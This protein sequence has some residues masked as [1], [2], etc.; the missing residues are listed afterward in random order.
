MGQLSV[1]VT[2]TDRKAVAPEA[3]L[4]ARA[5][6]VGTVEARSK[7]WRQRVANAAS[8]QPLNRLYR[9]DHWTQSRRLL[10]A[11]T[12]AGFDASLWVASAGLGLQP[13]SASAPAYAATFSPRH[14]DAV[15]PSV[16][17]GARWWSYL[18][19]SMGRA[20]LSELGETGPILMVLSEMYANAMHE[21]LRDLGAAAGETLMIGG[22]Q[23]IPGVHRVASDA[24][25]S[26]ALG[27]TLTSL[28]VRMA[29]TWL[30]HCS[31]GQ[32]TSRTT[33]DAWCTWASAVPKVQRPQR[34]PMTDTEVMAFIK[35]AT[36]TRAGVSRTMLLR[37]LRDS[38]QACEQSRFGSLYRRVV[39]D[40]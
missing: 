4:H 2:C 20:T 35:H 28:N 37:I 14:A 25:L 6:P 1:V 22:S 21:E 27:G 33:R 39:G 18:Q 12:D 34:R 31:N 10:S 19:A 17:D 30:Q 7:L 36:E 15:V 16:Q 13:V 5:L 32:L 40:Q 11:A 38:G 24:T 3:S 23:D 8:V 26:L 29:L 9:G